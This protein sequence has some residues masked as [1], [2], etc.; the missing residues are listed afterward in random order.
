[1]RLLIVS[2]CYDWKGSELQMG[3][4]YL[5]TCEL[6]G[7]SVGIAICLVQLVGDM[8]KFSVL[9]EFRWVYDART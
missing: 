9:V 4:D 8:H 7:F 3:F 5:R 1:M 6:S 2:V